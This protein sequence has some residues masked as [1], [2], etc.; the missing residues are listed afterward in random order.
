MKPHRGTTQHG[1]G[2]Y[3][4]RM[5]RL[6]FAL[7]FLI[8]VLIGFGVYFWYERKRREKIA[9]VA[10]EIGFSYAAKDD[11]VRSTPL[12][13][14][15]LFQIGRSRYCRNV[16][17]GTIED[18]DTLLFD[19]GYKIGSGDNAHRY[20]MSVFAMRVPNAHLP[21]F[22]LKPQGWLQKIGGAFGFEDVDF[23][24]RP[25]FS[26]RFTLKG[27]DPEALGRM[28]T[29]D[30]CSHIVARPKICIEGEGAWIIVFRRDGRVS[31]DSLT[32]LLEEGFEIAML[33]VGSGVGGGSGA[34][35][36]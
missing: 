33:L 16:V 13:A 5:D 11:S 9:R 30:A 25:E 17:R 19:Y 32:G 2:R 31:P 18:L 22:A 20:R 26:S 10:A 4:E 12:G 21:S 28:F 14:L 15:P 29:A 34:H 27:R 7:G 24:D 3:H 6:W 23:H 36:S 8:L 35:R 1:L